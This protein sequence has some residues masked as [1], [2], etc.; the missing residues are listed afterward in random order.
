MN[1]DVKNENGCVVLSPTDK[2]DFVSAPDFEKIIEAQAG[3]AD[4]M[5]IDMGQ[6][7]YISSAGLRAILFA[8]DLMSEKSGLVLRNVGNSVKEILDI[9]GF[10]NVI[11][12]E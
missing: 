5:I 9:S 2:I 3:S 7:E 12:I 1:V 11:K 6:V 10:S 8:D 4:R